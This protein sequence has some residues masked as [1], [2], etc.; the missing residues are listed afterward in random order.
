MQLYNM[1]FPVNMIST[2]FITAELKALF[3]SPQFK[4]YIF[5]LQMYLANFQA[6][7]FP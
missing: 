3:V 2:L 5:H 7:L 6:K 1:R 4:Q